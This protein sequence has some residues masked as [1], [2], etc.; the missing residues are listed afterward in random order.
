MTRSSQSGKFFHIAFIFACIAGLPIS[1]HFAYD[2]LRTVGQGT[3]SFK[4]KPAPV[5]VLCQITR[6]FHPGSIETEEILKTQLTGVKTRFIGTKKTSKAVFLTTIDGR[7]INF[8]DRANTIRTH[9]LEAQIDV[10]SAFIA[11]LQAQTLSIETRPDPAEAIPTGLVLVMF[12]C[13]A[14]Q[15]FKAVVLDLKKI[16]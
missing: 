5:Q 11:D 10:M 13:I 15:A 8:S 6:Q 16:G 7:E 1:L 4:C 14:G 12:Y 3:V 9:Q 2:A